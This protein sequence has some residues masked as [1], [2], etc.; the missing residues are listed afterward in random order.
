VQAHERTPNGGSLLAD[1]PGEPASVGASTATFGR[2]TGS[3]VLRGLVATMAVIISRSATTAAYQASRTSWLPAPRVSVLALMAPLLSSVPPDPNAPTVV[4]A[5]GAP[6]CPR[7]PTR[8]VVD[9]DPS[10]GT[11]S[12]PMSDHTER[13]RELSERV[14]AAKEFL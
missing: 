14:A 6:R 1:A 2:A 5:S 12:A 7:A 11:M 13:L 9:H 8:R 4:R 10:P 3:A